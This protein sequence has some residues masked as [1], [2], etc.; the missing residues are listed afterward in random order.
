MS[1]LPE[2]TDLVVAGSGAAGLAAAITARRAGLEVLVLEKQRGIAVTFGWRAALHAASGAAEPE[3][4]SSR[5]TVP[6]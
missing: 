1:V 5:A 4:S 6:R 2:V 3:A